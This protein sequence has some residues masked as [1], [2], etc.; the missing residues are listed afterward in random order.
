MFTDTVKLCGVV[1]LPG[2]T[3]S[4]LPPEADALMLRAEPL[5]VTLIACDAGADP[6][7]WNAKL[8]ELGVADSPGAAL[9]VSVTWTVRGLLEAPEDVI[10]IVPL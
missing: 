7:I 8:S 10:V 5:L 3:D 4:Q 9:T 1:P 2:V 6:P